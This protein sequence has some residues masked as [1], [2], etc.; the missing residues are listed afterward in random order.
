MDR[1][2]VGLPKRIAIIVCKGMAE[3]T[4]YTVLVSCRWYLRVSQS[5]PWIVPGI[6]I[7]WVVLSLRSQSKAL[8]TGSGESIVHRY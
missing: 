6:I 2:S 8:F 1:L 3:E 4:P 7:N 5:K